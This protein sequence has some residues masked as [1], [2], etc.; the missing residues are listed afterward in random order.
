[1]RS[2]FGLRARALLFL[3]PS[4]IGCLASGP[5][6]ASENVA[7]LL[8]APPSGL[9]AGIVYAQRRGFYAQAGLAATIEAG[10]G[11]G[12]T[13]RTVVKQRRAFGLAELAAVI[14]SR[15]EDVDTVGLALLMERFPGTAI[16]LKGSGIQ[17]P[18]A[19]EGRRLAAAA[20]SFSRILFPSFAERAG[21]NLE[22][23]RWSDI[24]P[25]ASIRALLAG[26]ADAVVTAET[27]RW[28]FERAAA[29]GKKEIRSF[30]YT[31]QGV[32]VYSLCLLA[33]AR[34][35]QEEQA[36]V[37]RMVGAT[38]RGLAEAMTRPAEAL[39]LFRRSF[40]EH[41]A[42]AAAAEWKVFV[43]SWSPEGLKD[44]GVGFFQ[45]NRVGQLQALLVRGRQLTRE[46]PPSTFFTNRF[47]PQ[48][49][50]QPAPF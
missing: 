49:S 30:P 44:P 23:V 29:R 41:P 20:S 5:V 17:K 38:V 21:I 45:E 2:P 26:E 40:P 27:V 12:Q 11:S 46:F 36:L 33:P 31:A 37:R 42:E 48:V 7:L 6:R 8:N 32:E 9:H 28:R 24:G 35:V 13:V 16:T 10:K 43:G 25:T 15:A 34:L 3:L 1:M 50:V 22:N 18:A 19:L 4:G 39:E 47:V 14:E